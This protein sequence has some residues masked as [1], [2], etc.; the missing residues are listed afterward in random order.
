MR[1]AP[2]CETASSETCAHRSTGR[3]DRYPNGHGLRDTADQ[4]WTPPGQMITRS[5][6]A[7][8]AIQ[9]TLDRPLSST[10][11]YYSRSTA[12]LALR[13]DQLRPRHLTCASFLMQRSSFWKGALKYPLHVT[14]PR[15]QE[16]AS[17][18]GGTS[19]ERLEMSE[20]KLRGQPT[21]RPTSAF[22]AG[23][24]QTWLQ[25]VARAQT[26]WALS[27]RP[28]NGCHDSSHGSETSLARRCTRHCPH[29]Q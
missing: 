11:S 13:R 19:R 4:S 23:P 27:R 9:S 1:G 3:V 5:T 16:T 6:Q 24:L 10:H 26:W 20:T 22:V 21:P 25:N 29:C 18:P 8:Q 12:N 28:E 2:F 7:L 15:L 14:N 17:V